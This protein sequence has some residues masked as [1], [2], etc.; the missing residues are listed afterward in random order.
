MVLIGFY[1]T[2]NIKTFQSALSLI[3]TV[4][5]G[6]NCPEKIQT[7]RCM[8]LKILLKSKAQKLTALFND[9]S[10]RSKNL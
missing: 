5:L 1:E 8:L 2:L 6:Y 10:Q 7:I 3:Q 4:F 9:L